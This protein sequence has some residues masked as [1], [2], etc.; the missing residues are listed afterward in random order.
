MKN[1]YMMLAMSLMLGCNSDL[2]SD[3]QGTAFNNAISETTDTVYE[4]FT[5]E[6][7]DIPDGFNL[8]TVNTYTLNIDL[9]EFADSRTFVSL[10]TNFDEQGN[11]IDYAS[12]ILTVELVAGEALVSFPLNEFELPIMGE[13][14][15]VES[16][17][18][19]RKKLR[20]IDQQD[21][22]LN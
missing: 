5:M 6:D 10:Y 14:F 12:K 15:S 11:A 9:D 1:L 17:Q 3:S 21:E 20:F 18:K 16:N 2:S 4:S 8:N 19:H 22:W 7:L 13:A